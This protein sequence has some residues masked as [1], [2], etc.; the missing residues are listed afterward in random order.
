MAPFAELTSL[1]KRSSSCS[2]YDA[3]CNMDR[4]PVIVILL[5]TGI[6]ASLLISCF[7]VR[8]RRWRAAKE[9][10]NRR[11]L[12][13]IKMTGSSWPSYEAPPPYMPRVP[14]RVAK[15]RGERI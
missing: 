8:S 12:E 13:Q 1:H 6:I 2:Y 14:E 5:I 9:R 3:T 10:E 4:T 11:R 7:Y 15:G